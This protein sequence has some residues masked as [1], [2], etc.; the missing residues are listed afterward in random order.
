MSFNIWDF[1]KF[2]Q[3]TST[4]NAYIQRIYIYSTYYKPEGNQRFD[5]RIKYN[6]LF[7]HECLSVLNRLTLITSFMSTRIGQII[8]KPRNSVLEACASITPH[9]LQRPE[10]MFVEPQKE[11][12]IF[13]SVGWDHCQVMLVSLKGFIL[14]QR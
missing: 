8:S 10:I 13:L 14:D 3:I 5:R 1:L 6:I 4:L 12:W 2:H 9:Q 7:L 11:D